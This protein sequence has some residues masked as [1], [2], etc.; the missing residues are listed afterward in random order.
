MFQ[1]LG[2]KDTTDYDRAIISQSKNTKHRKKQDM[3]KS[4]ETVSSRFRISKTG[5]VKE[6]YIEQLYM[7]C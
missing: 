7:E 1:N 6:S 4:E 5:Y 2:P 3:N